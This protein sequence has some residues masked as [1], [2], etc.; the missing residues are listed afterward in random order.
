MTG[1]RKMT[2]KSAKKIVVKGSNKNNP[3]P[4]PCNPWYMG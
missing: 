2:T 3:K 1:D 4:A